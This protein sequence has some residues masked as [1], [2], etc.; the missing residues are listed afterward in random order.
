MNAKQ[1]MLTIGTILTIII[2][3]AGSSLLVTPPP[4]DG[5]KVVATFYPLAFLSQEIGGEHVQVTQLVPSNTE[6]HSWEPTFSHIQSTENADIIVYNGAGADHWI[7]DEILPA[8]STTKNRIVVETTHGIDL[9]LTDSDEHENEATE[10]HEHGLYDAHTWLSPYMAKLQAENIYN[11]IIQKDPEHQSY[12]YQ[13]WFDL[14]NRLEQLDQEYLTQLAV[15]TKN[16]IFVSHAAFGY[17]ASRYDF[18][19]HGVIGLSADEQPSISSI[20]NIVNMMREHETYTIYVD[21]VYSSEYAN[22]LKNELQSKTG[23][24]VTILELYLMLGPREGKDL[25]EQMQTN[26]ANLKIGLGAT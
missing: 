15:K 3:I 18:E 12:Y 26:L 11:A 14:N 19:Q 6:I 22:T 16:E 17:L 20:T 4:A 13:R 5:V 8:L 10:D 9:I 24:T 2:V 23:H 21:P 1:K 25:I 7:E